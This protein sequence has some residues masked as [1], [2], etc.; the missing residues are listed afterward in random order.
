MNRKEKAELDKT[1]KIYNYRVAILKFD[2]G[3]GALLCN[4][5]S[6]VVATGFS[7]EDRI[8]LCEDCAKLHPIE[9]Q[10]G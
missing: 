4:Q 3:L 7:H 5:C 2:N 9:I 1:Q 6:K 10:Y 8:H